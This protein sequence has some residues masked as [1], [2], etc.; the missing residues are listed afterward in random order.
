VAKRQADGAVSQTGTT[1][2]P[3]SDKAGRW[4]FRKEQIVLFTAVV[5]FLTALVTGGIAVAQ[6]QGK[7]E[8]TNTNKGLQTQ[9]DDRNRDIGNLR[10]DKE[11]LRS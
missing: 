9:L 8:A 11:V 1:M 4:D 3:L 6:M 5:G 10:S 2:G 7:D